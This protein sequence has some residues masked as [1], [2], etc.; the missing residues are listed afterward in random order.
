[1]ILG[2]KLRLRGAAEVQQNVLLS[3]RRMR[4]DQSY[5]PYRLP[6]GRS[7]EWPSVVVESGYAGS[8]SKL[9]ADAR[10]WLIE[11]EGD[12]WTAL[13]VLVHGRRK[14]ISIQKWELA[15]SP[16]T[17]TE[18]SRQ[19]VVVSQLEGGQETVQVANAPLTIAFENCLPEGSAGGGRERFRFH[20]GGFQGYGEVGLERTTLA[21]NK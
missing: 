18:P 3:G 15:E 7:D 9:E 19:Q 20:G 14:E 8:G 6:E 2:A 11:A 10:W 16:T 12:V 5:L 13:V 1:M 21:I 4:P 17:R